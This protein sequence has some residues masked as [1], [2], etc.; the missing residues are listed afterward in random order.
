MNRARSI[1]EGNRDKIELMAKALIEWETLEASQIDDIMA[2]KNPRPPSSDSKSDTEASDN[3]GDSDDADLDPII[4]PK[5]RMNRPA[6]GE[7]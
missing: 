4:K 2:G 6:G 1:I 5:P 7:T 3:H